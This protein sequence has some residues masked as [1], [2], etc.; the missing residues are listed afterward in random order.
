MD[1][2]ARL[3]PEKLYVDFA[4]GVTRTDPIMGRSYT[5][6]HSDTTGDLFLTVGLV[7]DYSKITSM[8]DEVLGRWNIYYNQ[9]A[10]YIYLYVDG[11]MGGAAA[12]AVRNMIFRRELPLALEAIRYGDREFFYAHPTLNNAPI[13][14]YFFSAFPQYNRVENWGTFADYDGVI[15]D[16]SGYEE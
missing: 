16:D 5:L 7:F 3:N 4:P 10:C 15:P 11:E 9:Y 8:R 1:C 13:I 2:L 12:S 6:T 14:V